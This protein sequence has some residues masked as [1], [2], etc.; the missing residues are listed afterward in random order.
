MEKEEK[1]TTNKPIVA[2]IL[3]KRYAEKIAI[4][5]DA[6]VCYGYRLTMDEC[7][8]AFIGEHIHENTVYNTRSSLALPPTPISNPS[9]D[10]IRATLNSE[11]SPYYYYLHDADGVIHYGKTLE[12]HNRN[13]VLYLGR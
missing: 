2:G 7:T 10:T 12:E 11:S 8:P 6:T 13:K 4:G 1:S 9:A 5:A 3:K